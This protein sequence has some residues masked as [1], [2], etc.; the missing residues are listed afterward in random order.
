M[1]WKDAR[2]G[3]RVR[4]GTVLSM[5]WWGLN[6]GL[7]DLRRVKLVRVPARLVAFLLTNQ[8]ATL[9]YVFDI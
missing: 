7:R 4:C 1:G 8:C 5:R 3:A 9:F 6:E 2:L